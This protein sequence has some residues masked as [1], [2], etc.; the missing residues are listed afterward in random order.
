MFVYH[1]KSRGDKPAWNY[2]TSVP[3]Q[4]ERP[5]RQTNE[6]VFDLQHGSSVKYKETHA[7][8]FPFV[9]V[10]NYMTFP[11]G[12]EQMKIN[13]IKSEGTMA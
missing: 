13:H 10:E 8:I 7:H 12:K 11:R 1:L 6:I 2:S 4:F 9:A 3:S 5:A